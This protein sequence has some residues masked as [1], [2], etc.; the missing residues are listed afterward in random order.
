MATSAI[1]IIVAI[2]ALLIV[3]GVLLMARNR[4][5]TRLHGEAERIREEVEQESATVDR[6]EALADETAAKA[7]AARA[8]AEAKDAEATR[9]EERARGAPP[10]RGRQPGRTRGTPGPRRRDRPESQGRR[11]ARTSMSP[12]RRLEPWSNRASG[13]GWSEL[14][15][16]RGPAAQDPGVP[17]HARA[18]GPRLRKAVEERAQPDFA[19]GTR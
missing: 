12:P 18:R 16:Q 2:V 5:H 3:V 13:V 4:R 1:W 7:R 6:R 8:E 19:L 9:L 10:R 15:R 17:T 11:A 14:D